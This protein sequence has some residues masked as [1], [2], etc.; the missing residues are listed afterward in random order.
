MA[1]PNP[2]MR[3]FA[4]CRAMIWIAS[5]LAP[6]PV[7]TEWR[8]SGTRQA[9]HWCLF[10]AETGR[11]NRSNKIELA[12][13]CWSAFPAALWLR[14]DREEFLRRRDR[15]V[16][17]PSFCL[18]AIAVAAIAI[19]LAGG[20]IPAAR[21]VISSP[22]PDPDR[23][24]V[25]SLNGKF[26]RVR[27]ETLLDLAAAWRGSKLL[28][29]VA[30]Y[31]WA[32][33]K[34]QTQQRTVPVLTARVGPEFFQVLQ[35]NAAIGRTFRSGD[36][37]GCIDCAML[38]DEIWRYQFHADP[39]IVGHQVVLD[40]Y[41][42][43]IIGILPRNF[44]LLAANI[45]AWMLLDW[46]Q[47]PYSNFLERI[48]AVARTAPGSTTR[49]AE[50]ELADL[51][52]NAGYVFPAS[53]ITVTSGP[54]ELRHYLLSYLL[55]VLLAVGSAVLIVYARS[56]SEVGRAPLSARDRV[57]WW[58]FFVAKALLLLALTGL[59]A[60]SV[61]RWGSIYLY[62]STHPMTNAVA[63]WVFLLFAVAPLSWA[64]RD[65][66]WRCR[67]CLRRLGTPIQI[68]A[69]GYVLL[70]WSGTEM[71][72]ADGHGVLY[73]PDSQANWLE[74]ARWDNLDESWADLF[75]DSGQ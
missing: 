47:P 6:A 14:F 44:R 73:L 43:T 20:A 37:N 38:S 34:L 55:F 3:T 27:T 13:F 70:D 54:G 72:C 75:K 35:L 10:L 68:G 19:L 74:R 25:V 18:T 69:P 45:S 65:Q 67:V 63:L 12:R 32:A 42:R 28:T 41:P 31:S 60:W 58:S 66:Q 16:G 2:A 51:T 29:A 48:G 5:W 8:A 4:V 62:G 9:L 64:I 30:P 61:V 26:R 39:S 57:R 53:L 46:A 21:S 59:L 40:G 52:E 23:V 22:I 17:S 71:V 50:S 49:R 36:E 1:F 7:R 33:G 11:L 15:V 24:I 56:G